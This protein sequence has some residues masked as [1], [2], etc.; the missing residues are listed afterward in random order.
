MHSRS[1][2]VSLQ[3]Q[4]LFFENAKKQHTVAFLRYGLPDSAAA[5]RVK[6]MNVFFKGS[7]TPWGPFHAVGALAAQR[8][9]RFGPGPVLAGLAR[10]KARGAGPFAVIRL[11]ICCPCGIHVFFVCLSLVANF[12]KPIYSKLN[13]SKNIFKVLHFAV[14]YGLR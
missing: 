12:E 11:S 4:P 14:S 7:W 10:G 6:Q 2:S 13:Y 5:A 3:I 9:R 8:E 1:L